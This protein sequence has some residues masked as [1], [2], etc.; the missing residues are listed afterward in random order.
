MKK[1]GN[2]KVKFF[3]TEW[4]RSY[5][6]LALELQKL[7]SFIPFYYPLFLSPL[8][9][10]NV[11][12]VMFTSWKTEIFNSL[13]FL[14]PYT[15]NK[16]IEFPFDAWWISV[17]EWKNH[18]L[19]EIIK[20]FYQKKRRKQKS[21]WVIHSTWERKLPIVFEILVGHHIFNDQFRL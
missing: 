4:S 3:S 13:D 21:C 2:F 7:L 20:P 16:T 10:W 12:Q 1:R 17:F 14:I 8:P 15:L 6:N 18:Y 9:L 11:H 19:L 5:I